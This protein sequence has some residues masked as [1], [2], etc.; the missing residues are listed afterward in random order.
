MVHSQATARTSSS[1]STS[2]YRVSTNT[3]SD[4]GHADGH[5]LL[6]I[7]PEIIFFFVHLQIGASIDAS[8]RDDDC[9]PPLR[10]RWLGHGR[11]RLRATVTEGGLAMNAQQ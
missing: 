7:H 6:F 9:E 5:H 3:S 10:S 11:Q 8:L 2:I 4:L 1:S